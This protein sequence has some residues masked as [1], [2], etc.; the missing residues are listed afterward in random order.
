MNHEQRCFHLDEEKKK[1]RKKKKKFPKC[2][3]KTTITSFSIDELII[4]SAI[5]S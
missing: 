3:R 5:N 4:T 2:Y 1:E